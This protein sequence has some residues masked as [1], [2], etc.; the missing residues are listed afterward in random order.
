L[1]LF[2]LNHTLKR[3]QHALHSL[4]S[5]AL[6]QGR[7]ESLPKLVGFAL[8]T[9]GLYFVGF[10]GPLLGS[11]AGLGYILLKGSSANV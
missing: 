10:L 2:S 5:I 11:S 8:R 1:L 3:I 6:L 4:M 9:L 7:L